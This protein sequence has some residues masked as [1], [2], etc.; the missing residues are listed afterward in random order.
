MLMVF[1]LMPLFDFTVSR[2]DGY[3]LGRVRDMERFRELDAVDKSDELG[4]I[5]RLAVKRG[6]EMSDLV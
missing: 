1:S 4:W 2:E 3:D 6:R 5:Y